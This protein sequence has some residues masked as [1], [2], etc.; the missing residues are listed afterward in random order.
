[1]TA[2]RTHTAALAQAT[3]QARD[4]AEAPANALVMGKPSESL[5]H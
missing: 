5:S 2:F 1:M 3:G 4:E